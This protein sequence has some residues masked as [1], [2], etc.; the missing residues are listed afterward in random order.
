MK[1]IFSINPKI[2]TRQIKFKKSY[3]D[4]KHRIDI[5]H[6]ISDGIFASKTKT[7]RP[8]T[9]TLLRVQL[10]RRT[11]YL[12]IYFNVDINLSS[13]NLALVCVPPRLFTYRLWV[14][15]VDEGGKDLARVFL[16]LAVST[17]GKTIVSIL[18]SKENRSGLLWRSQAASLLAHSTST[19]PFFYSRENPIFYFFTLSTLI[20]LENTLLLR[21]LHLNTF[22]FSGVSSGKGMHFS[23]V[24]HF[25]FPVDINLQQCKSV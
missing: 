16:D 2:L 7:I 13:R 10:F 25:F 12:F 18:K 15:D 19:R 3:L 4:C 22:S 11:F 8:D 20:L 1:I 5:Q 24:S 14:C 23:G 9:Q 21:R 6:Y 17:L